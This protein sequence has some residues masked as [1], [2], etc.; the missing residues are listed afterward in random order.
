MHPHL[1][2]AVVQ[3]HRGI[4]VVNVETKDGCS[5]TTEPEE[6]RIGAGGV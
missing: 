1:I 5:M 3:L 2:N 4:N 6:L